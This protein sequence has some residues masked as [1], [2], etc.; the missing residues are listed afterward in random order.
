[1]H[2][3]KASTPSKAMLIASITQSAGSKNVSTSANWTI[4]A[5]RATMS[6]SSTLRA[7]ARSFASALM[8]P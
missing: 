8:S 5:P 2:D 1:V 7:R 4:S 6:L 3:L